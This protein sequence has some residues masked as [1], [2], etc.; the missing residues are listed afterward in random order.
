MRRI[1]YTYDDGT[2]LKNGMSEDDVI[3]KGGTPASIEE[4]N[5]LK[6]LCFCRSDDV[7]NLLVILEK[8]DVFRNSIGP[9]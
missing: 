8:N 3:S 6:V 7:E 4:L 5:N 1:L 9:N 2:R